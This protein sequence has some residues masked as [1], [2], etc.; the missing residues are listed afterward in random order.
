[1]TMAVAAL[2]SRGISATASGSQARSSTGREWSMHLSFVSHTGLQWRARSH[3]PLVSQ[4][5]KHRTRTAPLC[6]GSI[7]TVGASRGLGLEVVKAL[8]SRGKGELTT[9]TVR[10]SKDA[11]AV[12]VDSVKIVDVTDEENVRKVLKQGFDVVIS[13]FGGRLDDEQRCDYSG[14]QN[15]IDALVEEVGTKRFVLVSALGAGDSESCLPMQVL[16]GMRSFLLDKSR[17]ELYLKES[18]L[19]YTIVRTTPLSENSEYTGKAFLTE[20][21]NCYGG[22]GRK[23]LAQLICDAVSSSKAEN[24][25]LYAVDRTKVLLTSPFVRPLEAWEALPDG[26]EAFEL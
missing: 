14:N 12:P 13:C 4:Y 8:K 10:Q 9:A 1:M 5:R 22:I 26:V 25:L 23:D 3:R 2:G 6:L 17:S 21:Q 18:G 16:R 20:S 19:P 24:K 15:L 11:S 7:L